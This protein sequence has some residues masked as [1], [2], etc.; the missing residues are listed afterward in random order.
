MTPIAWSSLRCACASCEK[1]RGCSF[2][3][4]VWTWVR[5]HQ[6]CSEGDA[7]CGVLST[8]QCLDSL[9]PSASRSAHKPIRAARTGGIVNLHEFTSADARP[10]TTDDVEHIAFHLAHDF[11]KQIFE[12]RAVGKFM[13]ALL[14]SPLANQHA[15]SGSPQLAS[16]TK[17]IQ[18]LYGPSESITSIEI[19]TGGSIPP[20]IRIRT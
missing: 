15:R 18:L 17:W 6:C 20:G 19:R 8:G 2:A 11:G 12:A 14:S 10:D 7:S 9:G 4:E 3:L 1:S 13:D 5:R 16:S